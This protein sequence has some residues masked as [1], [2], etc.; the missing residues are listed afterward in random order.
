MLI[1]PKKRVAKAHVQQAMLALSPE[2]K[3]YIDKRLETLGM[4]Y[5]G[6]NINQNKEDRNGQQRT[7]SLEI[8]Y[9][10]KMKG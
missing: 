10:E 5:G 9:G 1:Y 7:Y 6:K 2:A 4:Q 3:E 8:G